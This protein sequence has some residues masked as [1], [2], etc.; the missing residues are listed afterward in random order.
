V[1]LQLGHAMMSGQVYG[2]SPNTHHPQYANAS[3]LPSSPLNAA[4]SGNIPYSGFL[5][6]GFGQFSPDQQIKD[7]FGG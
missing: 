4:M 2:V 1:A 7:L 3:M 5:V 6:A